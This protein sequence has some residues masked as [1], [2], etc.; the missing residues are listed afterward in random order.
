MADPKARLARG[1]PGV[2]GDYTSRTYI[3]NTTAN[4]QGVRVAMSLFKDKQLELEE[5]LA[6][7]DTV[8]N[9]RP[10]DMATDWAG[11]REHWELL[12][13]T[14]GIDT[15]KLYRFQVTDAAYACARMLQDEGAY[16]AHDRGLGKTLMALV[17]AD[18]LSSY[19][20]VVVCPNSAKDPVWR[21]EINNWYPHAN[22][23]TV[24]GSEAQ[25]DRALKTW[26]QFGGFLLVHYEALRLVDWKKYPADLVVVDEAHRLSRGHAGH[27]AP[28]FYKALKKIPS[29]Y[30][31][32]LSGSVLV[33]SP[34][35]L[36][37]A[38]HWLFPKVYASRDRDWN[39]RYVRY[40]EGTAFKVCLGVKPNM[41]AQM[42]AELGTFMIVRKKE[43]ELSD[44]PE[45]I[46][47]TIKVDLSPGQ[48]K[49]YDDL[50]TKMIAEMPD[51]D[52]IKVTSV[53]GQL[54]KLRQVACGLDLLDATVSDSTKL[55]VAVDLVVDNL[56][57]KTVVFTWHRATA[58]ALSQRLHDR[59]IDTALVHGGVPT[60]M[61]DAV[62]RLFKDEDEPKVLIATIKTVG[63]SQNFQV[64]NQVVFVEHSWTQADMDQA[65][66]R[67]YRNGQKQ[68]VTVVDIVSR[69]TIDTQRVLPALA[70]K[71]QLA[72]MILGG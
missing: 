6:S 9:L 26:K 11:D 59:G 20:T 51:G 41:L 12:A 17:C 60:K 30:R 36:F 55:D 16:L 27:K 3:L 70:A 69:A 40:A 48:R 67:V 2:A 10:L 64:A 15:S 28:Q 33:N 7:T 62:I 14:D 44:L 4:E 58:V 72:K 32:A 19:H 39:S 21:A 65:R 24:G 22:C 34:E 25:R 56:P 49:V 8:P 29:Q 63:E 71:E 31:L 53:L 52:Q 45:L 23:Y 57:N 1:I 42:R 66:D 5:A 18:E 50:A 43:D 54:A 47:Q 61:R 13:D 68:R 46:R 38:L 37:G 35:D